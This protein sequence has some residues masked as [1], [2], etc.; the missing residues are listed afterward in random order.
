MNNEQLRTFRVL[1][2][3]SKGGDFV[4]YEI[5]PDV[6][7]VITINLRFNVFLMN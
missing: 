2:G 3:D 7:K 1:P 6:G 5:K 4:D